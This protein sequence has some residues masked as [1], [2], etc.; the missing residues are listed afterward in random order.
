MLAKW[1]SPLEHMIL[2]GE[3]H[4]GPLDLDPALWM[5]GGS[6]DAE[7]TDE[8]L[9]DEIAERGAWAPIACRFEV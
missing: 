8:I 5:K 7:G 4:L 2:V 3:G 9:G 1:G 6:W